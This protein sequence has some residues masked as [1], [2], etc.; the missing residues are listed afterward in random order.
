MGRSRRWIERDVRGDAGS[1]SL[2]FVSLGVL[3]LVPLVYLVVALA[4]IQSAALAAEGAVRQAARVFTDAPD[5]GSAEQR[6]DRAIALALGDHGVPLDTATV[7]LTC[8]PDPGACLDPRAFVTVSIEVLVPL[9]LLPS[10]LPGD[11]PLA[12]PVQ[13]SATQQVSRFGGGG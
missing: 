1:A 12:V 4:G 7:T 3:L 2:E 11:I 5:A 9:P 6:A 8:A 10:V 13:A